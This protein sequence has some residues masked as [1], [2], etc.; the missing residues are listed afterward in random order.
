MH[1]RRLLL[2]I[3]ME[4]NRISFLFILCLSLFLGSIVFRV[5]RRRRFNLYDLRGPQWRSFWLGAVS[6]FRVWFDN[7]HFTH[8][9]QVISQSTY[10]KKRPA[11]LSSNG[12]VN[13]DQL[14]ASEDAWV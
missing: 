7:F 12:C 14:G 8:A 13:M 1:C 5:R 9:I 10:I 6:L 2:S 3:D 11:N 4:S